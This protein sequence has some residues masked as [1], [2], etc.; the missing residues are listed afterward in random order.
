M[1]HPATKC[2]KMPKIRFCHTNH[3]TL[4]VYP[5]A[6]WRVGVIL[7]QINRPTG[8]HEQSC[9]R[10]FRM[11][12]YKANN[13]NILYHTYQTGQTFWHGTDSKHFNALCEV[14]M[15]KVN[16]CNKIFLKCFL[17][18]IFKSEFS[19]PLSSIYDDNI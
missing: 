9:L 14:T 11:K 15:R 10:H 17:E 12:T 5:T 18:L 16:N 8:S 13:V 2:R 1:Y 7:I 19:S 4:F 3:S 6:V